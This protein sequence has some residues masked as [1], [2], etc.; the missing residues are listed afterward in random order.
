MYKILENNGNFLQKKKFEC[1]ASTAV[2]L[3]FMHFL[4][5][6]A[7][8]IALNYLYLIKKKIISKQVEIVGG[9]SRG[10]NLISDYYF[11]DG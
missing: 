3:V 6:K 5:F 11:S 10:Q 9:T 2:L 1:P 4:I 8:K 7:A